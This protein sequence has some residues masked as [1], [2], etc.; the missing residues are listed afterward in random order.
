MKY[1]FLIFLAII[2]Y[3]MTLTGS[4]NIFLSISA[5]P[6]EVRQYDPLQMEMILNIQLINPFDVRESGLIARIGLSS[7]ETENH[8]CFYDGEKDGKSLWRFRFTPQQTGKYLIQF[9]LK[10]K[11]ISQKSKTFSINVVPAQEH[12]FLR[13]DPQSHFGFRFDDGAYFRG[14]GE[15][16]AWAENYE[17]YFSRLAKNGCNFVRIWMCPWNLALEWK[18]SGLGKYN[19]QNA[20]RL[21]SVLSLARR[22]EIYVMLCFDY[23]GVVQKEQGYFKE[24]KWNDNPYNFRNGG[25]CRTE[26]EFFTSPKAKKFYKQRLDYIV[27]RWGYSPQIAAWEFWNE[28]DLTAGKPEDVIRWHEE[29]AEYLREVDPYDHLITTSFSGEGYLDIWRIEEM[30]FSQ[31]HHYNQPDFTYSLPATI[32]EMENQF[33]K[34]HV[35]GEFG[36]DFRGPKESRNAD[37]TNLGIHNGLWAG[38]FSPTPILPLTWWWDSLIDSSDLYTL[39]RTIANVNEKLMPLL[40]NGSVKEYQK[41]EIVSATDSSEKNFVIFPQKPWSK[42]VRDKFVVNENGTIEHREQIPTFLFGSEKSDLRK[43]PTFE[44]NYASDGFFRVHIN[45]VS[46]NCLLRIFLDDS[47]ALEKNLDLSAESSDWEKRQW[48]EEWKIYQGLIN[49]TFA[50]PV[51]QGSHRIRVQNDG[52]DWMEVA[53]YEFV[54]CGYGAADAVKIVG[55]CGSEIGFLWIRHQ[56]YSWKQMG[57]RNSVPLVKEADISLPEFARGIYDL[58]WLNTWNGSVL[59][60]EKVEIL[61]NQ[62]LKSPQF[63][64]DIGFYFVRAKGEI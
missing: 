17:F 12:G 33:H 54:G 38:L 48:Q 59:K 14:I 40:A 51:P 15:N 18:E 22:Y 37:P 7:G 45:H 11:K 31:T 29:M 2:F 20:A 53:R 21:D 3:A 23:H 57:S 13:R 63:R 55:L 44:I 52:T 49:K 35:V 26:A 62:I 64:G 58:Q 42:N 32:S 25:P 6:A 60:Q 39:F 24:K 10:T 27:A 36:V 47:L 34:P 4:E 41:T 43:P 16:V 5:P 8:F 30:D 50:V 56:D 19:L 46:D 28:V 1:A 9:E 61:D